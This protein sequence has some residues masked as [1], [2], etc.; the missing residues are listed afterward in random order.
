MMME[1]FAALDS[2]YGFKILFAAK[3]I[4]NGMFLMNLIKSIVMNMTVCM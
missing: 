3:K 1:F 2:L 4:N